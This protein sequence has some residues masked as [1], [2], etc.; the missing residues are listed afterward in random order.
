MQSLS[1]CL[2][3]LKSVSCA[4]LNARIDAG[5]NA[6]LAHM[7]PS[8]ERMHFFMRNVKKYK[9]WEGDLPY[10]YLV[11]MS[12][13]MGSDDGDLDYQDAE[14]ALDLV[15]IS[16]LVQSFIDT[17]RAPTNLLVFVFIFMD[18]I[19]EENPGIILNKWNFHKLTFGCF[20]IALRY[21][22]RID[23][24]FQDVCE[25]AKVDCDEARE[26]ESYIM[27][28]I[29]RNCSVTEEKFK[30]AELLL[31]TEALNS[32]ENISCYSTLL[33]L[34][35]KNVYEAIE[36]CSSTDFLPA[37]E[38]NETDSMSTQVDTESEGSSTG[39]DSMDEGDSE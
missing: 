9:Y 34:Q 35:I 22:G 14:E 31:I 10:Q 23:F 26:A 15:S 28:L 6:Y 11:T 20:L 27:E 3:A 12:K 19:Q 1:N 24:S 8:D 13:L 38:M 37:K 18:R 36:L 7:L 25:R 16:A 29:E 39:E 32:P 4:V 17:P 33:E 5:T 30:N 21:Q 2:P